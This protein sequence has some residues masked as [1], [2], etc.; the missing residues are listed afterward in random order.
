MMA[1]RSLRSD[2]FLDPGDQFGYPPA[3][4]RYPLVLPMPPT[5]LAGIENGGDDESLQTSLKQH[6]L[7]V[8]L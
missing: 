4:K 1:R 8:E 7:L 6:S 2:A 5:L 3:V